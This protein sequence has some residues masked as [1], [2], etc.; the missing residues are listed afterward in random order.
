MA[1]AMTEAATADT[2]SVGMEG[3]FLT[4]MTITMTGGRNTSGFMLKLA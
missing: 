2:T 4:A 1:T 3:H